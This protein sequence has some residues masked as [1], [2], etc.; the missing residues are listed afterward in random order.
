MITPL[1]ERLYTFFTGTQD[2]DRYSWI[3]IPSD[4]QVTHDLY[5]ITGKSSLYC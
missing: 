2:V 5:G 1:E 4:T 3:E